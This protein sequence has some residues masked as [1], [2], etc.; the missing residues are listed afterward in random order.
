MS[1]YYRT[2]SEHIYI[3]NKLEFLERLTFVD[4]RNKISVQY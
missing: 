4:T 2:D 1:I 3:G